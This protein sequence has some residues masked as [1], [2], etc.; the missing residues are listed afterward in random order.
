MRWSA[1]LLAF[2][3]AFAVIPTPSSHFGHRM[4]AD[5]KLVQWADVISYYEKVARS[6]DHVKVTELG[7]T[8]EGRPFVLV[9]IAEPKTLSNLERYQQIQE[10]LAD[11]RKTTPQQAEAL[12]AEGKTVVLIT[13]SIHSTEVASTQTAMEFV[14]R[15]LTENTKRHEA[16]LKDTIFLLIPSLNPDGVDKVTSW[17]NRYAGSP[18][19]AAP[20]VELYHKYTGHDN[21][22]DWYIFSQAETRL[23]VEMVHNVWRPQIV[24]DVHEMATTGARM[25]VPPWVDPVDPN[26]DPLIVQQV[27]QLGLSLA[28]DLTAAGKTGVVVHGIYDLFTPARHYQ[29]YHGGLRLLTE[30]A[31]VRYATPIRVPFASLQANAR[32]YNAQKSSWNFLEPWPGGE[33]KLR[34]IVE[35]QL[36]AFESSLYSAALRREDFLRN[37]YRVGRRALARRSPYAFVVPESQHDTAA[38]IRMLQTLEFGSV[39]IEQARKGFRAA[40]RGFLK[41]DYIIRMAQPYGSFAKTLLETQNYPDLRQYPGGPPRTPYDVTAHSLPLLMGVQVFPVDEPFEADLERARKVAAAPGQVAASKSVSL[42]PDSSD[43]WRA[44]NRLLKAGAEVYRNRENGI[45]YIPNQGIAADVMPQLARTLGLSFRATAIDP[46]SLHRLRQA[47]VGV[48]RGYVPIIDEGWT[49]WVLESWEFPYQSIGNERLQQGNLSNDF[50][51]IILPD[52]TP[53]TLHAG[54]LAGAL[55]EGVEVPPEYTGGIEDDGAGALRN[56]ILAGGTVLAFNSASNYAIERL[57][58]PVQ[59]VLGT[60]SNDRFYAPGTLL[61][62]EVDTTH[63]LC[64]GMGPQEAVW[65]ESGPAF[66]AIPASQEVSAKE[67]LRYPGQNVLASGWLLGEQYLANRAA[68]LDIAR[69]KGHLVLFGIRQQYR[70][71]PNATFKMLFKGLYFW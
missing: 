66:E 6:S 50:D 9:T 17:Y 48:Y 45:F 44:V 33:W 20:M 29:C 63:P 58:A 8:T 62:V 28:V 24:Y 12:I 61:R 39:E 2:H 56:F 71:Q 7:K 30:S 23:V 34:D 43:A 59:N 16:I 54:Y 32:G 41:G 67:V 37:F 60:I 53:G 26:I 69:G 46:A 3:T 65:F 51:V 57:N 19:E 11:P 52:A 14:Y 68:V 64:A 35:Y 22:R 70:G 31:S 38:M 13:C 47:R 42:S 10:R 15:L 1:F 27:N 36:I 49:R 25:F 40:G 18:Y 55:Y 4:G 21:N 5:R